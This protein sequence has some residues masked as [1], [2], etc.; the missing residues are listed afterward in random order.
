MG[1]IHRREAEKNYLDV[2]DEAFSS[3]FGHFG[4][5]MSSSFRRPSIQV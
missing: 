3:N 2:S 1:T 4:L 5:T